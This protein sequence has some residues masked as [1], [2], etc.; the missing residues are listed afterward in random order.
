MMAGDDAVVLDVSDLKDDE[1]FHDLVSSAFRLPD[2]Y[3][4]NC[5]ALWDCLSDDAQVRL[6]ALLIVEGLGT[7]QLNLPELYLKF[8]QILA[9]LKGV[10]DEIEIELRIGN[11]AEAGLHDPNRTIY[12]YT[13]NDPYYEL[14]NFSPYGIEVERYYW[15]TVEHYF[16]A[17]KFEGLDQYE[18]IRDARTPKDAKNL[19]QSRSVKIRDDWEKVKDRIMLFAL[20]KKFANGRARSVLLETVG[21]RLVENAPDDSYWGCGRTGDGRNRLGAMLM[22]VREE[23]LAF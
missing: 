10:E 6:P 20:R 2:H 8:D 18:K 19:G 5:D 11:P 23:I 17:M 12:F 22:Q 4:R 1:S 9:E 21:V 7:M 16:Q 14:S 3:G 13:K 15:P